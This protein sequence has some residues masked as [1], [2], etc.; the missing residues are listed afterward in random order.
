M[1]GIEAILEKKKIPYKYEEE[2]IAF[3]D[4][5]KLSHEDAETQYATFLERYFK[6]DQVF[7]SIPS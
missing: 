1:E 2:F 7:K 4:F 5:L 6:A 3:C